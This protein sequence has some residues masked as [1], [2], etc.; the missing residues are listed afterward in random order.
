MHAIYNYRLKI[1]NQ[2]FTGGLKFSFLIK[3]NLIDHFVPFLPLERSHVILC[4]KD[5]LLRKKYSPENEPTFLTTVADSMQ[6]F[7]KAVGLFSTSGCKRVS[8][9]VDLLIEQE[10]DAKEKH[11]TDAKEKPNEDVL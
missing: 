8:Q 9:K 5:Y 11:E 4:I 1:N 10:I 3:N 2:H 6:Y 7:P